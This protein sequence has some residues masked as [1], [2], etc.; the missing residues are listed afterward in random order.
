MT[1]KTTTTRRA[2][3]LVLTAVATAG[4]AM[5]VSAPAGAQ[6]APATGWVRFAH[7][8]ASE[9]PV[10]VRIDGEVT[11]EDVSFRDVT[12]YHQLTAGAH[13]VEVVTADSGA[14]LLDVGTGTGTLAI[15]ALERWPAIR[16]TG[17]DPSGGMLDLAR[18]A[19]GERLDPDAAAR[20]ATNVAPADR[21]PFDDAAFDHS[22][23]SFVLQLV[24]SRQAALRE[25]LREA[26][27]EPWLKTSG[28]RGIHVFCP[29]AP[30]H[31]FLDVRHAVIAAGRELERRLPDRVTTGDIA[32][33]R[34]GFSSARAYISSTSTVREPKPGTETVRVLVPMEEKLSRILWVIPLPSP[35]MTIT[36]MMPMMMPRSGVER[37]VSATDRSTR[38]T[39]V[40]TVMRMF[41]MPIRISSKSPPR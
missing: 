41:V 39:M 27:L 12:E 14:V 2:V 9:G 7:F 26:G 1:T 13:R 6:T 28:N 16:V 19:A 35:T 21:L 11:E 3:R 29:I 23:S 4:L 10:D 15:A 30:T 5:A 38:I 22:V 24:R 40:G 25:V 18:R 31:E 36:A 33:N 32:S 17:I 37:F 34:S 20:F 8:A